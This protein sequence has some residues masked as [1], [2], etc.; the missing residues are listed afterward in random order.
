MDRDVILRRIDAIEQML[1][2]L[3][4]DVLADDNPAEETVK[5]SERQ[6][7]WSRSMLEALYPRIEHLTGAV[8]LL[9]VTA[10]NAPNAVTYQE[11]RHRSGLSDQEQR[12]DHT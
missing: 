2:D 4:K 8:A 3:R 1:C 12:N 9:D 10:E 6:G 5:V 7:T 11:I